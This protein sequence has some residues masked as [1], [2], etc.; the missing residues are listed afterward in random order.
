MGADLKTITRYYRI[1]RRAIC[2]LKFIL[3]SY[4]GIGTMSTVDPRKGV[5]SVH[6][7]PGCEPD[8]EAIIEEMRGEVR[9]ED[10]QEP[11]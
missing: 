10:L 5:I 6:I 8:V 1:D 9:L 7:A 4:D 11:C 2:L 3:E